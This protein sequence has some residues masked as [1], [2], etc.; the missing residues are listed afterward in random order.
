MLYLTTVMIKAEAS[1]PNIGYINLHTD[2]TIIYSLI[3]NFIYK[4][5]LFFLA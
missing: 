2:S 3:I 5:V 4:R 1:Q